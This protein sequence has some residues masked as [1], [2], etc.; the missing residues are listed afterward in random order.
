MAAK[1]GKDFKL[2]YSTTLLTS[3]SDEGASWN[4]ITVAQDVTRNKSR[5]SFPV[6]NRATAGYKT[7]LTGLKDGSISV[8]LT[9]DPEDTSYAALDAAFESDTAVAIMDLDGDSATAGSKGIMGNFKISQ[10]EVNQPIEGAAT[11]SATLDPY[12]YVHSVTITE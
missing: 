5:D 12:Q 3:L 1:A 2:Y 9:Y 4:E 7:K 10:F 8:E 11:V 6:S